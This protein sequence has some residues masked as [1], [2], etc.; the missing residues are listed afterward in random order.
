MRENSKGKSKRSMVFFNRSFHLFFMLVMGILL[1]GVMVDMMRGGLEEAVDRMDFEENWII[2]TELATTEVEKVSDFRINGVVKGEIITFSNT[3]PEI[4]GYTEMYLHQDFCKVRVY[5]DDEVIF[6]SRIIDGDED[7]APVATYLVR[8][9]EEDAGRPITI[10]YIPTIDNAFYSVDNPY[11]FTATLYNEVYA[12]CGVQLLSVAVFLIW[13]GIVVFVAGVAD[14]FSQKHRNMLLP[15]GILSFCVGIW[16]SCDSDG[17]M[18]LTRDAYTSTNLE[19]MSLYFAMIPFVWL[20]RELTDMTMNQPGYRKKSIRIHIATMCFVVFWIVAFILNYTGILYFSQLLWV[21]HSLIALAA[22]VVFV[23]LYQVKLEGDRGQSIFRVGLFVLSAF[24]IVDVARFNIQKY[25]LHAHTDGYTVIP[26]GVLVFV[27]FVLFSYSTSLNKRIV[28]E[29]EVYA[30]EKMAYHDSMTGLLN[31]AGADR[32]MEELDKGQ[33]GYAIVNYDL[34]CLKKTNDTYGHQAGDK[35]I[36]IFS[37]AIEQHFSHMGAVAR[38]GGDEFAVFVQESDIPLIDK[39]IEKVSRDLRV[40]DAK[41]EFSVSASYGLAESKEL[42]GESSEAVYRLA[43]RRM[44]EMKVRM[45]T[46]RKD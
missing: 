46:Q 11:L 24:G 38:M 5:L 28:E 33:C 10:E 3:V 17:I 7:V 25:I 44:Y 15:L 13:L 4:H 34:N 20:L 19:Y 18:I 23:T 29:A 45:K 35:L 12:V 40:A 42:P 39:A 26:Y 27:F 21:Y 1:L 16:T 6:D 9:E 8:L 41:E 36:T 43:D 30:L 2:T 22:V 31:R 37:T 32:V 14:C